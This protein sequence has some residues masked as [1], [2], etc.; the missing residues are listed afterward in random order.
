MRGEPRLVDEEGDQCEQHDGQ[1]D[2]EPPIKQPSHRMTFS[3]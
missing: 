1:P 3:A 2:A